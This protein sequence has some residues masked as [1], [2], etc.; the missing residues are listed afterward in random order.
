VLVLAMLA[1]FMLTFLLSSAAIFYVLVLENQTRSAICDILRPG[2][3]DP[4]LT[5]QQA[6]ELLAA[7]HSF[8]C[9]VPSTFRSPS[10]GG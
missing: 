3:A 1:L 8:S 5:A 6:K 4:K 10:A 7:L 9:S 2:L